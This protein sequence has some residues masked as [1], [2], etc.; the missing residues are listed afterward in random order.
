M[1]NLHIQISDST[2]DNIR[3]RNG[4]PTAPERERKT[5]WRQFLKAHWDGLLA[6]DFFTTEVLCW[7]GQEQG[8]DT[9]RQ[10]NPPNAR[11]E[12][13]S[14]RALLRKLC[15]QPCPQCRWPRPNVKIPRVRQGSQH[16]LDRR[17]EWILHGAPGLTNRLFSGFLSRLRPTIKQ[18][19]HSGK[20]RNCIDARHFNL[21]N[22]AARG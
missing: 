5:T 8:H 6:A 20:P 3:K 4:I 14:S 18:A 7:R 22:G 10:S 15:V 13:G 9:N 12:Q 21:L 1:A 2:V 11:R 19:L 17:R 16:T